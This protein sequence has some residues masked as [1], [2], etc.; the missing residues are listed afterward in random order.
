ME[1]FYRQDNMKITLGPKPGKG[2]CL[3]FASSDPINRPEL[4]GNQRDVLKDIAGF[5][6]YN[7]QHTLA[8]LHKRVRASHL[9][10]QGQ[11]DDWLL[12]EFWTKDKQAIRDVCLILAGKFGFDFEESIFTTPV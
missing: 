4:L 7:V 1:K 8:P 5:L 2:T 3:E 12:I 10:I 9:F 11:S 6:T